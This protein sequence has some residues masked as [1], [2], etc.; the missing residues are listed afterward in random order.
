MAKGTLAKGA[1]VVMREALLAELILDELKR[2]DTRP[3]CVPLPSDKRLKTLCDSLI[4]KP[5]TDPSVRLARLNGELPAGMRS[6]VLLFAPLLQRMKKI[7]IPTNAKG[8]SLGIR[9]LDPHLGYGEAG[10]N[11]G[12]VE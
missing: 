2:S 9:E 4:E 3:I 1:D 10:K 8:C 11:A 5:A 7:A 6:A 12:G